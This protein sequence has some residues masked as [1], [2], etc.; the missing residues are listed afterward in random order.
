MARN[1][2][3]IGNTTVRNPFRLPDGIRLFHDIIQ[4]N[5][6]DKAEQA[7]AWQLLQD[8]GI[9]KSSKAKEP[10]FNGRKWF[11]ALKQLGFVYLDSNKKLYVTEVGKFLMENPHMIDMVFLRQLVK[12][13]V[14]SPIEMRGWGQKNFRPLIT[15]LKF[16]RLADRNGIIGLTLDEIAIFVITTLTEDDDIINEVFFKKII[17]FRKGYEKTIGKV[18]KTQFVNEGIS[19]FAPI[20]PKTESLYDY[21]D[22]SARYARITGLVTQAGLGFGGRF[23]I[24]EGRREI[25]D[26]LLDTIGTP[27]SDDNYISALY[28]PTQPHLP[29][30]DVEVVAAEIAKLEDEIAA[31]GVT[32]NAGPNIQTMIAQHAQATL[33]RQRRDELNEFRFYRQ[34]RTWEALKDVRQLLDQIKRKDLPDR[35]SYAPA[36]LEWALWRL[37]LAINDIRNPISQTRGFRVD[38][39]FVPMHHAA[40][41]GADCTFAYDANAIV[42]EAT[43]TANSRQVVA[44]NESVRRHVAKVVDNMPDKDVFGLFVAQSVDANTYDEFHTGRYRLHEDVQLR[45]SIIPLTIDDVINLI[46]AM[47][48]QQHILTSE[49][50]IRILKNLDALR[51]ECDDGVTWRNQIRQVFPQAIADLSALRA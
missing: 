40:G 27:I 11:S 49:E 39:D 43:L 25:V 47:Q 4:G 22:S 6:W 33:L 21:A 44:E 29:I 5:V 32:P 7:R 45:L 3:D 12:Y 41:G 37:L 20:E 28:D 14:G 1:T 38:D 30:D 9:V 23:K 8:A 2:W 24:S 16:L 50:L 46:D 19:K 51:R 34:Q 18:A 17:P 10:D 36:F 31:L 42:V 48:E 26:K 15:F 35:Y 13:K